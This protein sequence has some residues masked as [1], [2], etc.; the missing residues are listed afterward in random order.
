M[1]SSQNTEHEPAYAIPLEIK[2]RHTAPST[3]AW[4]DLGPHGVTNDG[5]FYIDGEEGTIWMG[6]FYEDVRNQLNRMPGHN[7]WI[8][9]NTTAIDG[10][11][12]LRL[13]WKKNLN[14][15]HGKDMTVVLERANYYHIYVDNY[16]LMPHCYVTIGAGSQI[17]V[18]GETD[19]VTIE[20][21][22]PNK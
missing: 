2:M 19:T 15:V 7:T 12:L 20:F 5:M 4:V 10:G 1:L 3:N 13:D 14:S 6:K 18:V 22:W 17:C 11:M 21:V 9:F 16:L 8:S